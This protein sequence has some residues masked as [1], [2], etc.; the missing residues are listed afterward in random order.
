[1][2][3]R[4][5]LT[6]FEPQETKFNVALVPAAAPDA[7]P[8]TV[9]GRIDSGSNINTIDYDIA[10]SLCGNR[11][12]EGQVVR[13]GCQHTQGGQDGTYT[14]E[15]QCIVGRIPEVNIIFARDFG[16]SKA[17]SEFSVDRGSLS[18]DRELNEEWAKNAVFLI[19][20]K[21]RQDL[22][23]KRNRHPDDDDSGQRMIQ[24]PRTGE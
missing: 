7:E 21:T 22:L 15:I 13:V 10:T 23:R 3:E 20:A 24:R 4:L 2:V 6:C 16:R 11:I 5:T 19:E 14:Q 1:M 8:M 17:R 12:R 9:L 18:S